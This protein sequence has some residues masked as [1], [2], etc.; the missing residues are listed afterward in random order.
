MTANIMNDCK[1]YEGIYDITKEYMNREKV[2]I[3]FSKDV[4]LKSIGFVTNQVDMK[5][6][7]DLEDVDYINVAYLN[8]LGR[9]PLQEDITYWLRVSDSRRRLI[10]TILESF[11]F[12]MRGITVYN[13]PYSQNKIKKRIRNFL[14]KSSNEEL[15]KQ[16]YFKIF[17]RLPKGLKHILRKIV[18][19]N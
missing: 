6:W 16:W 12:H 14:F 18:I 11:E 15:R 3:P 19:M 1:V 2:E 7:D 13:N 5:E 17:T 8:L 10:N 9:F 4:F